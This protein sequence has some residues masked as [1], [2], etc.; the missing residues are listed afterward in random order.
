MQTH[1]YTYSLADVFNVCIVYN[2]LYIP[3][4][5]RVYRY[6]YGRM[7]GTFCHCHAIYNNIAYAINK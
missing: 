3:Y 2:V 5:V 7:N 6:I 4:I 1:Q